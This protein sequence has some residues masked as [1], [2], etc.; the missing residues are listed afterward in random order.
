MEDNSYF[1][2][3]YLGHRIT[4][5]NANGFKDFTFGGKGTKE[6][7]FLGPQYLA[8]DDKGYIYISDLGN[9]RIQKFDL[10]GKFVLA[11]GQQTE[12]FPGLAEPTGIVAQEDRIF[13]ADRKRKSLYLFDLSGNFITAFLQGK[14]TAP[15]GLALLDTDNLLIADTEKVLKFSIENEHIQPIGDLATYAKR[16]TSVTL[17]ANKNILA[18]DFDLNKVFFMT[19]MSNLYTGLFVQVDHINADKFPEVMFDV[20]VTDMAGAPVVGL[21]KS[22]FFVTEA[23][24]PVKNYELLLSNQQTEFVTVVLLVEKSLRA[25]EN[26]TS[27]KEAV[28]ALYTLLAKKATVLVVAADENGKIEIG[29]SSSRLKVVQASISGNFSPDW[30]F[31]AGIREAVNTLLNYRGRRV[32]LY[33]SQGDLGKAPYRSYSLQELTQYLKN[34]HVTLHTVY[35]N[36]DL[37]Q[38]IRYLTTAT[39]GGLHYYF[40]SAGLNPLPQAIINTMPATYTLRLTSLRQ[41]DLGRK[42]LDLQVEINLQNRKGRGESGYYTNLKF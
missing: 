11:F 9:K 5:Y 4:K 22:N 15:E 34:N 32:I 7:S 23:N 33:L 24:K 35:F 21:D 39:N 26:T 8:K 12:A 36:A 10:K 17:D 31:D 13:V 29:E 27:L 1:V 41:P 28:D 14:L 16:L 18:C 25:K 42:Y 19:E 37:H 2:S 3:E 40:Q 30:R 6:G 20:S 38:D